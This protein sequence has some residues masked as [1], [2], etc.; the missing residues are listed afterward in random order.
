MPG[1]ASP[2]QKGFFR[3]LLKLPGFV[4][5]HSIPRMYG[6]LSSLSLLLTN[7]SSSLDLAQTL[8]PG[9]QEAQ[10]QRQLNYHLALRET[11]VFPELH[12]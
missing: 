3:V 5:K 10:V 9:R 2:E 8:N 12:I 7:F 6:S 11:Q 1:E 4:S